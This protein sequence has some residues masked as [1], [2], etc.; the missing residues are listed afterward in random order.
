MKMKRLKYF[1]MMLLLSHAA[2][3]G[4]PAQTVTGNVQIVVDGYIIVPNIQDIVF[5]NMNAQNAY[6]E[7]ASPTQA[8]S[9]QSTFSPGSG[10]PNVSVSASIDNQ[11]V[12]KNGAYMVNTD[13]SGKVYFTVN[14]RSCGPAGKQYALITSGSTPLP[15]VILKNAEVSASACQKQSGLLFFMR[16][17]LKK[18][19]ELEPLPPAGTY[20]GQI[21]LTVQATSET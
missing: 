6:A 21:T 17:A 3:G 10:T 2:V 19:P 4:G 14:Y 1:G 20:T 12:D 18:T 11:H 13:Q 9:I 7:D 8:Y 5:Q 15:R 16:G